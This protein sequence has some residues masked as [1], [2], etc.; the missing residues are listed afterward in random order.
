MTPPTRPFRVLVC[1]ELAPAAE[2][3]FRNAGCELET[4]LGLGEAEL[5]EAVK[6]RDALVVRS[7]TKLT[8]KVIEAADRLAVIGRAGVGVDNIDC[9][10]A[11]ERGVV[12]MN[13]PDGNTLS[14]AELALAHLF[15]LA[16]HL[17]R[18]DRAARAG[19][20]KKGL[21][22]TELTGK[23]LGVIGLGRIGRAVAQRAL[24]LE[25]VVLAHDP[26]LA[27]GAESPVRGVELTTLD[28]LLARSDFVTLHVPLNDGTRNLLSRERL[29]RMKRGARV[30][31]AARGGLIDEAALIE[32]LDSG[33]LRGAAL[34]VLAE[35]PPSATNP[36]LARDDVILSPHLGASSDEA[37]R[38]VAVEIALQIVGFLVDGVA[39]NAVNAPAADAATLRRLAPYLKLAE[40][41]GS[42]LAQLLAE[43]LE[44]LELTLGGALADSDPHQ[45]R[46]AALVGALRPSLGDAVNFVNAP[47][48]ARE[49]A[50]E[51]FQAPERDPARPALA[52]RAI[53]RSGRERRVVGDVFGGAPRFVGY[54][55]LRIDLEPEGALIVTRHA[56][57][58]GVVGTVG[59]LLGRHG[60]N[61][62][63]IELGPLA[64]P[65]PANEPASAASTP[66]PAASGDALGLWSL[67]AAPPRAALLELAALP[68]VR[69]VEFVRF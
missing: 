66:T 27:S 21:M 28:D 47:R 24:G 5:C 20:K 6:G 26:F 55:E 7:A 51:L 48:F 63:R 57:Q 60:V 44:R 25:L 69:A 49:R 67:Y 68:T 37:Q 58:P 9:D 3:L 16:R 14:A 39:K 31:N 13:T 34:D 12:V 23:T 59:T 46:L 42:F 56:D 1:D 33:Q 29:A 32:A 61:I 8:R 11:T 17:P 22:G 65:A 2:E 45:P 4:R 36:L 38:N 43:P 19:W 15:A 50:L 30:I 41:A 18:A 54:G 10:A 52:L 40:R 64:A 53:G 62:R 35:E